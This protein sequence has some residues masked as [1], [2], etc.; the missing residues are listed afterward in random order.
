MEGCL[1]HLNNPVGN[2]GRFLPFEQAKPQYKTQMFG[3][4]RRRFG[5]TD[6]A[7]GWSNRTGTWVNS[8]FMRSNQTCW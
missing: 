6:T 4:V 8:L 1:N 2:R 3:C 7:T 5:Q